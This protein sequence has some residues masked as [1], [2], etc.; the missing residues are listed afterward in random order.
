MAKEGANRGPSQAERLGPIQDSSEEHLEEEVAGE[1]RVML[2][3][4]FFT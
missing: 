1:K 4:L 3:S 2:L